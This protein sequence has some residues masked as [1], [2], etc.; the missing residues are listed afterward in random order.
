MNI[1]WILGDTKELWSI[2][3]SVTALWV[4]KRVSVVS[5]MHP[6]YME[7]NEIMSIF[8][9]KYLKRKNGINEVND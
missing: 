8:D 2:L 4:G 9:S 6:D 3:L 1:H 5:R 7:S